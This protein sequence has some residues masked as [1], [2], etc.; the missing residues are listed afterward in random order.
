MSA[1]ARLISPRVQKKPGLPMQPSPSVDQVAVA[2]PITP[3]P[4]AS[5]QTAPQ[6]AAPTAAPLTADLTQ[7]LQTRARDLANV[8]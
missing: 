6:E 7:V 1:A 8:E 5:A 3:Q 2:E 4:T